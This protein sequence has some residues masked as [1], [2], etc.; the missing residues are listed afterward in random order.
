[1]KR[2]I[3]IGALCVLGAACGGS[4]ND[5]SNNTSGIGGTPFCDSAGA[6]VTA[7]KAKAGTCAALSQ[8]AAPGS[9]STASCASVTANCTAADK[10]VLDAW[11]A[12]LNSGPT[13]TAGGEVWAQAFATCSANA[14]T[15]SSGCGQ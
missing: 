12:C 14:G 15:I 13:C 5:N 10:A 8:P 1:M 7:W 9:G 4:S 6:F 11:T 3:L 2:T